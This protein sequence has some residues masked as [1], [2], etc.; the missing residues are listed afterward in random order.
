[1]RN[2]EENIIFHFNSWLR[3]SDYVVFYRDCIIFEEFPTKIG[4]FRE[5]EDMD[6]STGIA[7]SVTSSPTLVHA[8]Y[9]TPERDVFRVT[10]PV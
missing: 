6:F 2:L 4:I 9:I 8:W 5:N 10:W 3:F 7:K 1:M